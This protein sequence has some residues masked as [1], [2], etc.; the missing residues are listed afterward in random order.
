MRV[1]MDKFGVFVCFALQPMYDGFTA[2]KNK[3]K[4]S[5]LGIMTFKHDLTV[6]V[7]TFLCESNISKLWNTK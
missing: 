4:V 5:D 7:I 1:K 3:E 2:S 6:K